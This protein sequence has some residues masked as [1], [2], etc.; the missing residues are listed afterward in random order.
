MTGGHANGI[1]FGMPPTARQLEA[2]A[3]LAYHGDYGDAAAC[4]GASLPSYRN[5]M[6]TLYTRIGATAQLHAA[7]VLGWLAIPP[8]MAREHR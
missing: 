3:E 1:R 4:L 8:G 5:L 7:W 6:T 2:L